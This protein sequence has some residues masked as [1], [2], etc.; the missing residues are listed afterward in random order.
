MTNPYGSVRILTFTRS[1]RRGGVERAL[2]RLIRGWVDAGLHVTLVVG[3]AGGPHDGD[4]PDAVELIEHD[5]SYLGMVRALPG[6][7]RRAQPDIV[8]CPG[9]YYSSVAA[10]MRARLGRN[11]P[12]IVAK[13]SNRLDRDDQRFPVAQGYRLWLRAHRG[14]VDHMV[15]MTPAMADEAVAMMGIGRDRVSVIANPPA[16]TNVGP[17]TPPIAGSD[18]LI[19]IGRLVPQKR[20]DRVITALAQVARRDVK[21]LILG[22]GETR[23]ALEKQ[24]DSLGLRDRVRMPG[25]SANPLPALAEARALVLT[26]DFEGVPGVVQEALA[27]G[28]PV[29]ATESSVAIRELITDSSQGS[30]LPI[31]DASALIAALDH[32]L[33]VGRS[34]P[35]PVAQRGEDSVERY[36][37]LFEELVLEH[38]LSRG[39]NYPDAPPRRPA[40]QSTRRRSR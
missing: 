11:C 31:G 36:I 20:W 23:Q 16:P 13:L 33:V 24:I 28:T 10:W 38:S 14:F 5:G 15:A 30:V 4:L 19:G 6:A 22:E 18:Y 8:F 7:A 34:R 2:L 26:S 35:D 12:P 25:Y 3:S 40:M 1:L 17:P 9:N 21:L 27:V 32:W 29:V 37:R 39:L